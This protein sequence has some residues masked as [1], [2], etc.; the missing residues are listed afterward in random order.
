LDWTTGNKSL[1]KFI[2]ESWERATHHV[3]SYLQWI[4]YNQLTNIKE[5]SRLEHNCSHTADWSA[6]TGTVML[7][8]IV[9]GSNPQSFDFYEV[10]YDIDEYFDS[11]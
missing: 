2:R 4:P 6:V 7:K 9:D 5:S 8:K 1:D 11:N 3:D 10:S